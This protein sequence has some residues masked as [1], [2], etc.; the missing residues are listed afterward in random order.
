MINLGLSVYQKAVLYNL[1][2]SS[3]RVAIKLQLMDL[4]H[5][6]IGDISA[7]FVDGSVDIDT[8][9][10]VTR[11][12]SLTLF[13]KSRSL[14]LAPDDPDE[15]AAFPT[16]MIGITYCVGSLDDSTWFEIPIFT[17]PVTKVDRDGVVLS[18]ECMGKEILSMS[19]MWNS[20]S[21]KKGWNK[22]QLM[23]NIMSTLAGETRFDLL[24]DTKVTTGA[25]TN[26]Q[27][28]GVGPWMHVKRLSGSMGVHAFYD[29]RGALRVRR[30]PATAQWSFSPRWVS[31]DPQVSISIDELI[32]AVEIT[33]AKPKGAKKPVSWK[34]V[35]DT[36]HALSPA[37]LSRGGVGGFKPYIEQNTDLTTTAA[38]RE[39]AETI[40]R[41]GLLQ[42]IDMSFE[43]FL[44]P[45]LEEN[46]IIALSTDTFSTDTRLQKSTI[47]LA[48][49][50]YM[51]IGFNK[52][53]RPSKLNRRLR[54]P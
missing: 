39:Y 36:N 20:K 26:I 12:A 44:V 14:Q 48:V 8:S 4:D 31:S 32:N 40:L 52:R 38:C 22:V 41:N 50:E 17:G 43:S 6:G 33:G 7:M 21:Y 49:G 37:S 15:G 1:L 45:G 3:H 24:G 25:A 11:S 9:S 5:R 47:P 16:R 54:R 23:R 19:A 27:R 34:A 18:I 13:D 35:A 53:V 2:M 42:A 29:G 51:S 28:G 10:D 46:D 30:F